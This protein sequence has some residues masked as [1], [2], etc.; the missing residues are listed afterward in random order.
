MN[1]GDRSKRNSFS[2]LRQVG[3]PCILNNEMVKNSAV[4][5]APALD[6]R[7]SAA[8]LP[9]MYEELKKLAT[10]LLNREPPG[11]T[12]QPTAL[13]HEAYLRLIG[14]VDAPCWENRGHFF[15]AAAQAMRRIL[16]DSA[17]RK[18]VFHRIAASQELQRDEWTPPPTIDL[19]ALD[20]ALNRLSHEDA[21]AARV[22][23]LRYFAGL[24]IDQATEALGV[25]RYLVTQKWA[26]ARSWLRLTLEG[27]PSEP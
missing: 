27:P 11:Q 24:S 18:K 12:L 7:S 14:P 17:R 3:W 5:D 23:E 6:E 16:V 2:Q 4:L 1:P 10:N 20:D 8:L 19:I 25:T 21:L 22:V 15:A 13:V 9:A 26:Y